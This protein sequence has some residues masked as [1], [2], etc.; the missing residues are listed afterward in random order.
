VRDPQVD[1]DGFKVLVG[2]YPNR[3]EAEADGRRLGR[4]YFVTT[5]GTT[6]P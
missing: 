1:G 3:D 5:T 6:P 4:P 2:P